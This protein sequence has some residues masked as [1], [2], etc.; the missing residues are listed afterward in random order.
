MITEIKKEHK[1]T[2]DHHHVIA[3]RVRYIGAHKPYV[4]SHANL[5]ETLA[6]LKQQVL[7]FFDLIEGS[8]GNGTKEYEFL[9]DG[10]QLTNLSKKLGQLANGEHLIKLDLL[11]QF[12]QG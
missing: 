1:K 12:E 5:D 2:D 8:V 3:V 9:H 4:N 11:E 10:V 6:V 7:S